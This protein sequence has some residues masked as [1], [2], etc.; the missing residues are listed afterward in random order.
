MTVESNA[1]RSRTARVHAPVQSRFGTI[2]VR[3]TARAASVNGAWCDV[4]T[5]FVGIFLFSSPWVLGFGGP[6]TNT[7]TQTAGV[8]GAVIGVTSVAA[9]TAFEAWEEYILVLASMAA[10]LSPAFIE[11]PG[12]AAVTVALSGVAT[13]ALATWRLWLLRQ[14]APALR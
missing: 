2:S 10:I 11:L 13:L 12:S 8:L 6:V 1:W 9:L 5:L 7:S 14:T 4:A 3:R